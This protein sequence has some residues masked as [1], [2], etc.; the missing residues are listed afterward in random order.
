VDGSAAARVRLRGWTLGDGARD[1]RPGAPRPSL[2]LAP[3]RA[4]AG[5]RTRA[6][7]M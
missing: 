7:P 2:G 3:T 6:Q 5:I 1:P 4:A